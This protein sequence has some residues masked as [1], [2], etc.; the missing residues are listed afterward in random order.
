VGRLEV[1]TDRVRES[2][3]GA[4]VVALLEES[5]RRLVAGDVPGAEQRYREVLRLVERWRSELGDDLRG[6]GRNLFG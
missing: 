6:C 5:R 4:D 1:L 3:G 2:G